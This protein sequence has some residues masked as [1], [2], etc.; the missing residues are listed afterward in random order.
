MKLSSDALIN[1][2]KIANYLLVWRPENDKSQFLAQAGYTERDADQLAADIREQLLSQEAKFEKTTEYG[3]MYGIVGSL[4]GPN[5]QA[6]QVISIWM[7]E[8][9]TSLTKFITLYPAKED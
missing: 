2:E 1:R 5:G 9:A 3:E 6:L 7:I 8:A 4:I